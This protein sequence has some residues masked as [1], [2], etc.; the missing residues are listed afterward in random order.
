MTHQIKNFTDN[1]KAGLA[2]DL[3]KGQE[4][5]KAFCQK[6][7]KLDA[8]KLDEAFHGWLSNQEKFS[9]EQVASGLGSLFG[10][11]LKKDFSF[12]WRMIE[13]Q[14]G[15]EPAL[16]DEL[17]GSIVFPVNSVWKR[18]EPQLQNEAFFGPMYLT[19]KV[20]IDNQKGKNADA[21]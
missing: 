17:S 2:L 19:I 11:L 6:V 18:I 15:C 1:E 14:F 4:I 16:V 5:V 13:D 8:D 9:A 21:D 3:Q 20:H 10:E 12:D 7:E